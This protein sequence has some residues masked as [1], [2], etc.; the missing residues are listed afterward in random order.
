MFNIKQFTAGIIV[1]PKDSI[2]ELWNSNL[3]IILFGDVYIVSKYVDIL[4]AMLHDKVL[5]SGS[6]IKFCL[7]CESFIKL[8]RNPC[9]P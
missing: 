5:C 6:R 2:P 4:L 8:S 7:E 1:P 9:R 3:I